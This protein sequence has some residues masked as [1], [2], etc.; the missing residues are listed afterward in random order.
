MLATSW[1][2]K[3]CCGSTWQKMPSLARVASSISVA[4]RQT[5]TSGDRPTLRSSWMPCCVGL[6]FCSPTD[7]RAAPDPGR[8]ASTAPR[9][10]RRQFDPMFRS[11]PAPR[12]STEHAR[13]RSRRRRD[14]PPRNIQLAAA[15]AARPADY[16]RRDRGGAATR[17]RGIIQLAAA[18]APCPA[19]YPARGRGGGGAT[20]PRGLS[21]SRPRRRRDSPPRNREYISKARFPRRRQTRGKAR[22]SRGRG[23]SSRA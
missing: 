23:R 11:A 4:E 7:L 8:R 1:T 21:S 13:R 5:S 12:V 10:F 14:S 3:T 9:E 6:V 20:R 2:D 22:G 15:A 18:A 17:P 16:P 19:D